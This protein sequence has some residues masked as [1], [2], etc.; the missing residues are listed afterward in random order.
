MR[1]SS[2]AG[3]ELLGIPGP[4]KVGQGHLGGGERRVL[5]QERHPV[6][7]VDV[8]VIAPLVVA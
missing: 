4:Q 1:A 6:A 2:F 5:G 3:Q 7:T 8:V